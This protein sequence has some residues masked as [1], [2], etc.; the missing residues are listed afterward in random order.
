VDHNDSKATED[1]ENSHE[2]NQI[3]VTSEILF[4]PPI[5]TRATS[6]AITITRNY[7]GT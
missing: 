3:G 7:E 2:R 6:T 4:S 5:I 1:V